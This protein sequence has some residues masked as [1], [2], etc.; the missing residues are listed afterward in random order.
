MESKEQIVFALLGNIN[1]RKRENNLMDIAK[2]I[3]KLQQHVGSLHNVANMLHVSVG[4]LQKF[5][6]VS[7]LSSV[8]QQLVKE[9][10]IDSV[11]IVYNLAKF[12]TTEQV[13]IAQ[14]VLNNTLNSQDLRD[15][16]PLRK[17]FPNEPIEH[18]IER[19][20][21]SKD[22]KIS[23]IRFYVQDLKKDQTLFEQELS[24]ILHAELLALEYNQHIGT[25]KVSQK[26]EKMLRR[27]AKQN[28]QTLQNYTYSLLEA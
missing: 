6:K 20:I 11:E 2:D 18:L 1:T 22:Q 4:M 17:N 12:S 7:K 28:K 16:C 5:L 3:Q 10:K 13:I 23:V 19:V 27:L 15:L 14:A 24:H 9:R 8:V 21:K 26:G 25:I